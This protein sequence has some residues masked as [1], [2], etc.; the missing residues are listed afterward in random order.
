VRYSELIKRALRIVWDYKVLWIR[1]LAA[2][3]GGGGGSE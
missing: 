2:L 1:C 3:T